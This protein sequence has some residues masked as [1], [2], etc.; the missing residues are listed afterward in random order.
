M[1][2]VIRDQ[3]ARSVREKMLPPAY[4]QSDEDRHE[5]AHYYNE[6]KNLGPS[7]QFSCSSN[8]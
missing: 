6:E 2:G 8:I 3:D 5:G 4:A 1:A 7:P